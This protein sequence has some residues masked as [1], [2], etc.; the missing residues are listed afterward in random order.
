VETRQHPNAA[1]R[2]NAMNEALPDDQGQQDTGGGNDMAGGQD[3]AESLGG[4][5]GEST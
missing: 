3:F 5:G 1:E 2:D 4:I